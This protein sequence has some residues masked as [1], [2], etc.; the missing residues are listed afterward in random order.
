MMYHQEQ[1][2]E[3]EM[4][5]RTASRGYLAKKVGAGKI[6]PRFYLVLLTVKKFTSTFHWEDK[7][8]G[9]SR[10]RQDK[11]YFRIN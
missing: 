2:V 7:P 1:R 9:H 4:L 10:Q 11:I 5:A 3:A 8:T 6:Q